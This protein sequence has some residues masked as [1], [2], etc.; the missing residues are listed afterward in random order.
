[1]VTTRREGSCVFLVAADGSILLQ[2][3]SD[4]VPPAGIGRWTPPGGRVNLAKTPARR[5]FGNSRRR[6]GSA[7]NGCGTSKP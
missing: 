6:R 4:D 2:Q 1:M 7:S 3:R 5:R